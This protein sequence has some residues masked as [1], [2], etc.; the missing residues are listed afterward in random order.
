MRIAN[1]MSELLFRRT[2]GNL[3][4]APEPANRGMN[5]AETTRADAQDVL[6]RSTNE[7]RER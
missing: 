1:D 6:G 2:A 7:S 3:A 5:T 4:Y